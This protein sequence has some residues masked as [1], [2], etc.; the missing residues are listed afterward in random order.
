MR[1]KKNVCSQPRFS[2]AAIELKNKKFSILYYYTFEHV[3]CSHHVENDPMS[4]LNEEVFGFHFE[5]HHEKHSN[6]KMVYVSL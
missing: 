5:T 2:L 6:A 3:A 4:S 1:R